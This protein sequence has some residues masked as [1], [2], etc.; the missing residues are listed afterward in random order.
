MVGLI[1]P[2]KAGTIMITVAIAITIT[3]TK[4]FTIASLT[5]MAIIRSTVTIPF[6][7]LSNLGTIFQR[8]HYLYLGRGPHSLPSD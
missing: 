5:T 4:T 6:A 1:E 7:F 3:V 2:G 8:D